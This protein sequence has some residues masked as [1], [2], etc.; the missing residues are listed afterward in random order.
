MAPDPASPSEPETDLQTTS[1]VM[2]VRDGERYLAEALD[3]ILE[4]SVPPTEVIVVDDGSVDGTPAVLAAYGD[5]I[6]VVRQPPGGQAT[7]LN[8]GIAAATGAY[9]AFLD[10]DD[11]WEPGAQECRL[12]RLRGPDAP[13][14]VVGRIVQ[15]VSP[16]LGPEAVAQFR[17]DP[18]PTVSNLLQAMV[19]RREAFDRVGPFEASLPSAAN[20]DWMSR[21]RLAGLQFVYVEN[22]VARRRLHRTNMGVTMGAGRLKALTDVVRMHHERMHTTPPAEDQPT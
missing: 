11:V 13:D 5:A 14:A 6:R 20:I 3:S 7:A 2:A 9:L 10:A 1:L 17:F 19:I 4:Q 22:V 16:E 21:A 8:T 18:A 12:A 15:F